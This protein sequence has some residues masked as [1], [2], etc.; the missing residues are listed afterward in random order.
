[1]TT[2]VPLYLVSACASAE[3]FVAAFRRYADRTGIFVPVSEPIAQ[4]RRGR[5][6]LTLKDGGV[7]LE[8]EVEITQS[9]AKPVGLHGRVGMTLRFVEPDE[10]TKTVLGELEKARLAMTLP[11]PTVTPRPAEIP[12]APRAVPPAVGGRIDAANALAECVVIG[13][14]GTL[15]EAPGDPNKSGPGKFV[16]PTIPN[17]GGRAHTPSTPP[18]LTARPKTPSTPP[19]LTPRPKTPSIPPEIKLPPPPSTKAEQK[20][21]SLG[22][23]AMDRLPAE[24]K[25]KSDPTPVPKGTS[26]G[27]P[28]LTKPPADTAAYPMRDQVAPSKERPRD[29][30]TTP[31]MMRSSRPTDPGVASTKSVPPPRRPNTPSTPPAPR[32]PTPYAPLPIVRLPAATDGETT[33]LTNVPQPPPVGDDQ[34]KSSLGV[35][36]MTASPLEAPDVSDDEGPYVGPPPTSPP[37]AGRSGG[38]RASEIMA[39][40]PSEDWTMTPDAVAPTV[41]PADTKAPDPAPLLP[42]PPPAEDWT[43]K[44]DPEAPDGWGAPAAVERLPEPKVPKTGNRVLAVASEKALTAVEWEDKPTGIGEPLVQIDPTLMEPLAPMPA[45]ADDEPARIVAAPPMHDEVPTAAMRPTPLPLPLAPAVAMPGPLPGSYVTPPH[46]HG[47]VTG[48][49]THQAL[50]RPDVTDGGTG[51]F[52]DSAE[53][54]RYPTDQ[55]AAIDTRKRKR[56]LVIVMSSVLVVARPR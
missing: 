14:V 30:P 40:I 1:M 26:M 23:P 33:D 7:M 35:A 56:T 55:H 53:M 41:L 17:V 46:G 16:I 49:G 6:A 3:E 38:M 2:G 10:L 48:S 50:P 32:T 43:I 27:M 20:M 51:F 34:R 13:D 47:S 8:G 42:P 5:V 15:R 29:D 4:G 18:A 39:A 36:M 19:A 24:T 28:A 9:S 12:S 25:P 52:R 22:M 31:L 21:T 44:A 45:L 54:P 37:P 11:T